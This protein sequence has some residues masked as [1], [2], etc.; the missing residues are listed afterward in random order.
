MSQNLL[1]LFNF[2]KRNTICEPQFALDSLLLELFGP[3]E[4]KKKLSVTWNRTQT[5]NIY[6]PVMHHLSLNNIGS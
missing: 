5:L 1:G 4:K 2:R 3:S 6:W